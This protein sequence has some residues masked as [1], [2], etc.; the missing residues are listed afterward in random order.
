MGAI[1]RRMTRDSRAPTTAHPLPV[2]G[3]SR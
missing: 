3:P 1:A 2:R